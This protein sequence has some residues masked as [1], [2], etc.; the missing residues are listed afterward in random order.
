[1]AKLALK[2]VWKCKGPTIKTNWNKN[3]VGGFTLS[4]FK[5]SKGTVIKTV[6]HQHQGNRTELNLHVYGKFLTK[7]QMQF[8]RVVV[9]TV[10]AETI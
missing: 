9:S 3:K 6:R 2:F 7:E 5:N 10:G 8:Q 4:D 1:M